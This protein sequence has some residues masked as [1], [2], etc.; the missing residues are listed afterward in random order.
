MS[1]SL[2]KQVH[3]DTRTLTCH[4]H[5]QRPVDKKID[6]WRFNLWMHS[7][8]IGQ[9][10][11]TKTHRRW[12]RHRQSYNIR[13]M[14]ESHV[15]KRQSD[16]MSDHVRTSFDAV[17]HI[18]TFWHRS[19]NRRETRTLL[20]STHMMLSLLSQWRRS[21]LLMHRTPSCSLRKHQKHH[22]TSI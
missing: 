17:V 20:I 19:G 4:L 6:T 13:C 5:T 11:R 18:V 1:A 2:L 15:F 14:H 7:R 16:S 9:S 21:N 8:S 3:G 22:G 10:Y 12:I